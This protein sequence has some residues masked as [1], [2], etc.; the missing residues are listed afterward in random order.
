MK[1]YIYILI[2][3]NFAFSQFEATGNSFIER[4]PHNWQEWNKLS[5]QKQIDEQWYNGYITGWLEGNQKTAI[6]FG[7][8]T[9]KNMVAKVD[10]MGVNQIIRLVKK[11][12]DDNPHKTHL[13]LFDILW[14]V[15][16]SLE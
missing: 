16:N 10:G 11:W 4:Y 2:L 14:E 13:P 6:Q 12:C 3:F 5:P 1:I 8:Y 15:T 9:K 7:D